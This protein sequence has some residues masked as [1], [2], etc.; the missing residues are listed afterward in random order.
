LA[1]TRI[2]ERVRFAAIGDDQVFGVDSAEVAIAL[3]EARLPA[4]RA[5]AAR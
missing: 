1:G 3:V 2:D 5:R 4:Y